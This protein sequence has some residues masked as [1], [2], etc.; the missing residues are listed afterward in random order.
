[1]Y[2]FISS[3]VAVIFCFV[4]FFLSSFCSSKHPRRWKLREFCFSSSQVTTTTPN[5][6]ALNTYLN[7]ERVAMN[8]RM[9][10]NKKSFNQIKI[11]LCCSLLSLRCYEFISQ[12]HR[13]LNFFIF[14]NTFFHCK[15]NSFLVIGFFI[16]DLFFFYY[17]RN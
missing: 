15:N 7:S 10:V 5:K 12:L 3:V 8:A 6:S 17:E 11:V 13:K 16:S 4:L 2:L 9:F 14:L 1:M